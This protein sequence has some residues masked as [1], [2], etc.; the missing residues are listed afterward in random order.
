MDV[1]FGPDPLAAQL[2]KK[3]CG[4]PVGCLES[5]TVCAQG[6]Q[7][8]PAPACCWQLLAFQGSTCRC[9]HCP[10][11]EFSWRTHCTATSGW[12]GEQPPHNPQLMGASHCWGNG[13]F[14][15][16]AKVWVGISKVWRCRGGCPLAAQCAGPGLQVLQGIFWLSHCIPTSLGT[17]LQPS[18]GGSTLFRVHPP[19]LEQQM[20]HPANR[21]QRSIIPLFPA[22]AQNVPGVPSLCYLHPYE[23][24]PLLELHQQLAT[25]PSEGCTSSSLTSLRAGIGEG[26]SGLP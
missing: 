23:D 20:P 17:S 4:E 25:V 21:P 6:R 16:S 15:G 8:N 1:A 3:R 18:P 13:A 12:E 11:L 26:W 9:P 22:P 7:P 14:S 2:P 5:I 19:L 24:K 10:A